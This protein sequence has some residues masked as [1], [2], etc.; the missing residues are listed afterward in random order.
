[1]GCSLQGA[2]SDGCAVE[3]W[4][5]RYNCAQREQVRIK[6]LQQHDR[7][8]HESGALNALPAVTPNDAAACSTSAAPTPLTKAPGSS[9]AAAAG[10]HQ[11]YTNV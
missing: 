4:S 1:M 8:C 10:V 5:N 9:S 2:R 6:S 11:L 7:T 3:R